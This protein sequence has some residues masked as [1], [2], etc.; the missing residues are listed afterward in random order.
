MRGAFL[1][2]LTTLALEASAYHVRMQGRMRSPADAPLAR[3][4]NLAGSSPL[5]NSADISYYTNVTLGGDDYEVLIDT[6]RC[7]PASEGS[8][9]C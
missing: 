7:V 6:G 5:T 2:A 8:T 3:R 1:A 4:G 9:S